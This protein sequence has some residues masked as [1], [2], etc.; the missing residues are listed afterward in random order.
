MRYLFSGLLALFALLGV[1]TLGEAHALAKGDGYTSPPGTEVSFAGGICNQPQG[2]SASTLSVSAALPARRF[3]WKSPNL[4][5]GLEDFPFM[6]PGFRCSKG[7]RQLSWA[8]FWCDWGGHWGW[9]GRWFGTQTRLKKMQARFE[10][11]AQKLSRCAPKAS[12]ASNA[13]PWRK[14]LVWTVMGLAI[15]SGDSSSAAGDSGVVLG[16]AV[17]TA[18]DKALD[19]VQTN[20]HSRLGRLLGSVTRK[21]GHQPMSTITILDNGTE[22][23]QTIIKADGRD[24]IGLNPFAEAFELKRLPQSDV[25][26]LEATGVKQELIIDAAKALSNKGYRPVGPRLMIR[27]HDEDGKRLEGANYIEA[28]DALL[29]TFTDVRSYFSLGSAPALHQVKVPEAGLHTSREGGEDKEVLFFAGKA[30]EIFPGLNGTEGGLPT[31][32]G[33]MVALYGKPNPAQPRFVLRLGKKKFVL[34]KG[35]HA[36]KA[37]RAFENPNAEGGYVFLPRGHFGEDETGKEAWRQGYDFVWLED[38]TPK[39]P[40]K[41]LIKVKSGY[42]KVDANGKLSGWIIAEPSSQQGNSLVSY[43]VLALLAEVNGDIKIA[44]LINEL[45][46]TSVK[47][48]VEFVKNDFDELELKKVLGEDKAEE[49]R[50]WFAAKAPQSSKSTR[51][52]HLGFGAKMHTGYVHMASLFNRGYMVVGDEF[53]LGKFQ[54]K[55]DKRNGQPLNEPGCGG[56]NPILDHNQTWV[57]KTWRLKTVTFYRNAVRDGTLS[58]EQK[59]HLVQFLGVR[60]GEWLDTLNWILAYSPS[61]TRGSV[62]MNAEDVAALAGDDDGDQLWFSFRN[63]KVHGVFVEI[64]RQNKGAQNYSIE[65]NKGAQLPSSIGSRNFRDILDAK[66]KELDAMIAFI[67]APNKGQG[68]VGYLA[69]LCTILITFFEKVDNGR[70]GLEFKNIW[71]E[72]LQAALNLMQQTSI[73]M[74]KRIFG[75]LC[76]LRWTL[77][78]LRKEKTPEKGLIPGFNYP[79]L[80]HAFSKEGFNPDNFSKEEYARALKDIGVPNIPHHYNGQL[81]LAVTEMDS[82]YNISALGS[83]LI[84]ESISLVATGKPCDWGKEMHEDARGGLD[85]YVLAEQL[86]NGE[87]LPELLGNLSSETKEKVEALWV[88]RPRELYAWKTQSKRLPFA[89]PAPP[90]L[91]LNHE[92]ALAAEATYVP[93][94]KPELGYKT[95]QKALKNA[96]KLAMSE[97]EARRFVNDVLAGFYREA[98]EAQRLKTASAR[99]Q[100]AHE[101]SGVEALRYILEALEAF[102]SDTRKYKKLAQGMEDALTP[103]MKMANKDEA[104]TACTLLFAWKELTESSWAFDQVARL[105]ESEHEV[106]KAAK[107]TGGKTQIWKD[108]GFTET[109]ARSAVRGKGSR[110]YSDEDFL[111]KCES[112]LGERHGEDKFARMKARATWFVDEGLTALVKSKTRQEIVA[113]KKDILRDLKGSIQDWTECRSTWNRKNEVEM[114]ILLATFKD[115][116]AL[117]IDPIKRDLEELAATRLDEDER[118]TL[119]RD[120]IKAKYTGNKKR[121]SELRKFSRQ[122]KKAQYA[123][124]LLNGFKELA[125]NEKASATELLNRLCSSEN[126][127][128]ADFVQRFEDS[129]G[130]LLNLERAWQ[131]ATPEERETVQ[132]WTWELGYWHTYTGRMVDGQRPKVTKFYADSRV[133]WSL[134]DAEVASLCRV[135]LEDG[136]SFYKLTKVPGRINK[137]WRLFDAFVYRLEPLNDWQLANG[138]GHLISMA[139]PDGKDEKDF[140]RVDHTALLKSERDYYQDQNPDDLTYEDEL[141]LEGVKAELSRIKNVEKNGLMARWGHLYFPVTWG[142][143]KHK[144]A[145]QLTCKKLQGRAWMALSVLGRDNP[146]YHEQPEVDEE[147]IIDITST[148]EP[149]STNGNHMPWKRRFGRDNFGRHDRRRRASMQKRGLLELDDSVDL[150]PY[151]FGDD[152]RLTYSDW[153]TFIEGVAESGMGSTQG[154]TMASLWFKS[155]AGRFAVMDPANDIHNPDVAEKCAAKLGACP[156]YDAR[157]H[158]EVLLRSDQWVKPVWP[159]TSRSAAQAFFSVIRI[160]TDK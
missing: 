150:L 90:A 15:F 72:R 87:K 139:I 38:D 1:A 40:N 149:L 129:L 39:G 63:E 59:D 22:T 23:P 100:S 86:Q 34:L 82:M 49:L 99:F 25:L 140:A 110:F 106:R 137:T 94:D 55:K 91:K 44:D 11:L 120:L 58:D 101:R 103:S 78:D 41:D 154:L 130:P 62:L 53:G 131:R 116:E 136:V 14:Y 146:T 28:I 108:F 21:R 57:G 107:K 13:L 151:D 128:A 7:D 134:P 77:A 56:K 66:G 138:F 27:V 75:A 12:S 142:F 5:D 16:T 157:L 36:V 152:A 52:N 148:L 113:S 67:M 135:L 141:A 158:I 51:K 35:N 45:V 31:S 6:I 88:E 4:W 119:N 74:Q 73:D 121:L 29:G 42:R 69:N 37:M 71:V 2:V 81:M 97:K 89:V 3:T 105:V 8:A 95:V 109:E 17:L 143:E 9:R 10:D 20:P 127:F 30:K 43:Q 155:H 111:A 46:E 125:E 84:W 54:V 156:S 144:W 19:F 48:G 80:G 85:P 132:G 18:F 117:W 70:G 26:F 147:G 133:E 33:A 153:L 145:G 159:L 104:I 122:D 47:R 93:K 32:Q 98:G 92:L 83:W 61:L 126:A 160:I 96:F 124:S 123:H 60:E 114:E 68:P 112:Y 65:N 76:L 50:D 79:V 102:R 64:K 115:G 24:N 118:K